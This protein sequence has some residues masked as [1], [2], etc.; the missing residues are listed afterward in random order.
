MAMQNNELFSQPFHQFIQ[1]PGKIDFLA[2]KQ[3]LAKT[4]D[5]PERACFAEDERTRS[6]TFEPAQTIPAL[7]QQ[8]RAKVRVIELYGRAAGQHLP[9]SNLRSDIS[10]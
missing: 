4:A 8:A 5:F 2:H 3:L 10:H 9:H 7:D 6:P 1:S